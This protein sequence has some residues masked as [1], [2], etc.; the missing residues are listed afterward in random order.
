MHNVIKLSILFFM[1][2]LLVGCASKTTVEAQNK[3][4]IKVF[5]EEDIYILA[6]LQ[7]EEVKNYSSAAEMFKKTYYKSDKKEYLYRSLQNSLAAKKSEDVIKTI[8]DLAED[9]IYDFEL[10]RLKIIALVG[11]K[12]L[13]EATKLAL[14]LVEKSNKVD[15]YLL[16]SDI[17]VKQKN[18]TQLLST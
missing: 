9:D 13:D 8:D 12:R 16:V 7:L 14:S 5:D 17:Y 2:I 15:D 18:M 3:G 11:L 10:M 4:R 1:F 6:A